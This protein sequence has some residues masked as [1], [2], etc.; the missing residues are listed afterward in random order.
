MAAD[1]PGLFETLVRL[2]GSNDPAQEEPEKWRPVLFQTPLRYFVPGSLFPS[3]VELWYLKKDLADLKNDFP[4]VTSRVI[5]MHGD[6]DAMVPPAN[7]EYT[8]KMLV[9][10]KMINVV[11]LSGANHFIPW[12]KFDEIKKVLLKL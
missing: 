12:M 9:N 2:S 8:K 6:K 10:A 4:L 3:N 5:I 7:V 11:W 1:N